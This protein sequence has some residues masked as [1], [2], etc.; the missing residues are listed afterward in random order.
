MTFLQQ[1]SSNL[2]TVLSNDVV[3][4]AAS[5][6]VSIAE[7]RSL[8][9]YI[10]GH[11]TAS[12]LLTREDVE[13]ISSIRDKLLK[14]WPRSNPAYSGIA[15]RGLTIPRSKMVTLLRK[16][17]FRTTDFRRTRK[18][19][20]WSTHAGIATAVALEYLRAGALKDPFVILL[21]GMAKADDTILFLSKEAVK[22]LYNEITHF[23]GSDFAEASE[24]VNSLFRSNNQL[25]EIMIRT[26]PAQVYIW[27]EGV[28]GFIVSQFS[29][30][31]NDEEVFSLFMSR[32]TEETRR[33]LSERD[34]S[35]TPDTGIVFTCTRDGEL[36]MQ[37]IPAGTVSW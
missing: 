28:V 18:L 8:H 33:I 29:D 10:T 34:A 4:E 1:I 26:G 31:A 7:I 2:E 23:T 17:E 19:E 11:H 24:M 22:A 3:Y 6:P 15:F 16:G 25:E 36:N 5:D 14:R 13:N 32:A 9:K 35:L 37:D 12:S 21:A 30:I 27:C 20:S